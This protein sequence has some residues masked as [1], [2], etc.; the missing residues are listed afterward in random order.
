MIHLVV[1]IAM[2]CG[3]QSSGDAVSRAHAKACQKKLS[4]CV[5]KKIQKEEPEFEDEA[6][7]EC[8]GELD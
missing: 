5:L 6:L 2:I 4:A 1:S 7:L 8:I 3:N